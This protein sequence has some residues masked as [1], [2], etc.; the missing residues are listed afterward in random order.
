MEE[1][2]VVKRPP[3]S[4]TLAGILAF[5][6]HSTGAL[7]NGQPLKFIVYIIVLAGLI[8]M[9]TYGEG[10]PFAALLL[11]GFYFYQLFEAVQT[12]NRINRRFLKGEEVEEEKIEEFP[13]AVKAGSVFWGAFLVALGFVLILA[14]Y[15]VISYNFLFDLWPVVIIVIGVKLVTEYLSKNKKEA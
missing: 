8:T 14:N 6:L 4:S 1:K 5:F 11:A 7:Y 3:K 10:Q 15:D 9:Q 12:S 13:Q 2:V